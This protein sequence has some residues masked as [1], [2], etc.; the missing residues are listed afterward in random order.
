MDEPDRPMLDY[1]MPRITPHTSSIY[2]ERIA[3]EYD[4]KGTHLYQLP[5]FYGNPTE[6]PM[7]FMREFYAIVGGIPL[8]RL[9]ECQLR[10]RVFPSCLKDKAKNRL[11]S[12]QPSILTTWDEVFNKFMLRYFPLKKTSDL[13]SQIQNFN[14][15][16]GETFYE[17]WERY[18][19][20]LDRCPMHSYVLFDKV[21]NFYKGIDSI[22]QA[23]IDGACQGNLLDVP[24]RRIWEVCENL[25]ENSMQKG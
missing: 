21:K 8:N 19:D 17:A 15:F 11:I 20:L 24:L 16:D 18:K 2:L 1:V 25:S 13:K 23:L 14:Q 22:S 5:H 12:L 6:D 3:R 9:T 7:H 10:R 4:L